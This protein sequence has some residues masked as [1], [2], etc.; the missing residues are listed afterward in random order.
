M[1]KASRENITRNVS[2]IVLVSIITFGSSF[3]SR[4]NYQA[5]RGGT[6]VLTDS[7]AALAMGGS[8]EACCLVGLALI[9][10]GMSGLLSTVESL[11]T[12]AAGVLVLLGTC[13]C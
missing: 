3:V 2:L 1:I 9:A 7:A 12:I 13:L 11:A 4:H 5:N 8:E 10:I 6:Q